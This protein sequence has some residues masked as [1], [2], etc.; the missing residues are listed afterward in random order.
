[1]GRFFVDDAA[2]AP[3]QALLAPSAREPPF[4]VQ[5]DQSYIFTRKS[6]KY[7]K[8]LVKG[9]HQSE[10]YVVC[11][12]GMTLK[13][14]LSH[15]IGDITSFLDHYADG[16]S[17]IIVVL[18]DGLN[19]EEDQVATKTAGAYTITF[20]PVVANL[21]VEKPALKD[22]MTKAYEKHSDTGEKVDAAISDWSSPAWNVA[23]MLILTLTAPYVK[24]GGFVH[25]VNP[26][27]LK[28]L[29]E[30]SAPAFMHDRLR[31]R[32]YPSYYWRMLSGGQYR[33]N[34]EEFF[35]NSSDNP[36]NVERIANDMFDAERCEE[37]YIIGNAN[38]K[39]SM[40]PDLGDYEMPMNEMLPRVVDI[41]K[42]TAQGALSTKAPKQSIAQ[43]NKDVI[44]SAIL[45][46]HQNKVRNAI[47]K[48]GLK[49]A[50]AS[51]LNNREY[52]LYAIKEDQRNWRDIPVELQNDPKFALQA[53][54]AH[55]RVYRILPEALR[56]RKEIA[57]AAVRQWG[58]FVTYA[59][60]VSLLQ[61]APEI[62]LTAV[63][64]CPYLLEGIL[65]RLVL[66]KERK[67]AL[68]KAAKSKSGPTIDLEYCL[69]RP[70]KFPLMHEAY[71]TLHQ[72]L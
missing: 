24:I 55:W 5:H 34:I 66:S 32:T 48:K 13:E 20:V 57:L 64:R 72:F 28:P 67:I 58:F 26:A 46:N 43:F 4:S 59:V 14:A 62:A 27:V 65:K 16:Q 51:I 7:D 19:K 42:D 6:S 47:K 1:M 21:S 30:S 10:K 54:K 8:R 37:R 52:L 61:D 3:S 40:F 44:N 9:Q 63:A 2:A 49:K 39:S 69:A 68:L 33:Q 12:L 11:I 38:A 45:R 71:T 41:T 29:S 18:Y 36:S 35:F 60:P 25:V 15:R 56:A 50:P 22:A 53:V 70:D 23:N 17:D 31:D